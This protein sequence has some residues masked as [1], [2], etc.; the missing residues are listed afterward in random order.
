VTDAE[1]LNAVREAI[2]KLVTDG[3]Q[4]WS[5]LDRRYRRADLPELWKLENQLHERVK[6]AAR[7]GSRTR[8]A[9]PY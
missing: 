2:G 4:E 1:M 9:R 6:A 7:G 8:L 3:F 5:V